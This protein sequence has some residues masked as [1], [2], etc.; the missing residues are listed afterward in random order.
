[1]NI[2]VERSFKYFRLIKII[3]SINVII[4]TKLKIEEEIE[5]L[6]KEFEV[7]VFFTHRGMSSAK[8]VEIAVKV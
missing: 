8:K 2:L 7:I 6:L 3:R 4:L 5:N 1:M